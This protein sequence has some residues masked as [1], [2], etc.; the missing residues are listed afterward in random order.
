MTVQM[1]FVTSMDMAI[2]RDTATLRLGTPTGPLQ[3]D[4]F[5]IEESLR[6][7]FTHQTLRQLAELLQKRIAEMDAALAEPTA[8]R[9][10]RPTPE[11]RS[12]VAENE[13]LPRH[14][15]Q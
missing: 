7:V 5:A 11:K 8:T 10:F 2:T 4:R 13:D 14:A 9:S 12:V 6:V 1:M 3:A 15:L